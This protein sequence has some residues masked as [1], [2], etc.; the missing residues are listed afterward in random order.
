MEKGIDNKEFQSESYQRVFSYLVGV[1]HVGNLSRI[2]EYVKSIVH[3]LQLY[4]YYY[5]VC[6][7]KDPSWS[8]IQHFV[9]FLNVQLKSCE[10]SVFMKTEFVGDVLIGMKT[11]VVKFM[12]RMSR[13]SDVQ[14]VI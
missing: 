8:E 10:E 9:N 13:V 6:G 2:L 5:S 11:F 7:V 3:C 4:I 12:I 14:L 1:R